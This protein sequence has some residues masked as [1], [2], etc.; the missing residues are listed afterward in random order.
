[1]RSRAANSP[2]EAHAPRSTNEGIQNAA[3]SRRH[4]LGLHRPTL[5]RKPLSEATIFH[6]ER[7]T[8]VDKRIIASVWMPAAAEPDSRR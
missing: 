3:R 8:V 5:D 1:M 2:R 4:L 6:R 7:A